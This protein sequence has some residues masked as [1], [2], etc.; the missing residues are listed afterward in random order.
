MPIMQR[1]HQKEQHRKMQ[2]EGENQDLAQPAA[3][4]ARNE[5][6]ALTG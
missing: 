4:A 1:D 2:P 5:P 3:A 6:G